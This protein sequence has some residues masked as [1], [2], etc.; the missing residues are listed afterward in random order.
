VEAALLADLAECIPGLMA[1]V[2]GAAATGS[3]IPHLMEALPP[4]ANV[5]RYGNVRQTDTSMVGRVVDELVARICIGLPPACASL[6]DDT[7]QAM[8]A[9]INGV[10]S[11]IDLLQEPSHEEAWAGALERLAAQDGIHGLLRGRACRLLFDRGG[12]DETTAVQMSQAL[13]PGTPAAQS[14]AWLQGFL[15]GSGQALIH[16]PRL[17]RLVDDWVLSLPEDL[18]TSVLPLLRRT[19]SMFPAP[20]RRQIGEMARSGG[21]AAVVSGD[22]ELDP[23]RV[24]QALALVM[25]ILGNA[26]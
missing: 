20:E 11:A 23:A 3:D 24:E 12:A 4:L 1:A 2:E 5:L 21:R 16:H 19:F 14:A 18:F 15:H 17:W 25:M 22:I 10:Q 6:D 9:D 7:A 8:F 26:P 13:S